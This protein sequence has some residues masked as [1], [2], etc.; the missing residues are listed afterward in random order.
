MELDRRAAT[1]I[2]T[3]FPTGTSFTERESQVDDQLSKILATGEETDL[4]LPPFR[5]PQAILENPPF[6]P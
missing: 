3:G 5:P 6:T 1:I 2:A 4:D